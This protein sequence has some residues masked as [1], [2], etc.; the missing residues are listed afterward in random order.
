MIITAIAL[1][2]SRQNIHTAI[3]V[4][5]YYILIFAFRVI[6][7]SIIRFLYYII[8]QVT[9]IIFYFYQV[10]NVNSCSDSDKN[11]CRCYC[12]YYYFFLLINGF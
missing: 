8:S 2:R 7:V 4:F 1:P 3:N 6:T 12:C 9:K 11:N 10:I 5:R